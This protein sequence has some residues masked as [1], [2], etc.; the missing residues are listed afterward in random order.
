MWGKPKPPPPDPKTL[1]KI[2]K[3][4]MRKNG[5]EMDREVLNL[6]REEQ[7]VQT[8]IKNLARVRP[9]LSLAFH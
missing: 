3:R 2:Q 8:D 1:V 7:K 6:Q 5:R 4:E 9:S